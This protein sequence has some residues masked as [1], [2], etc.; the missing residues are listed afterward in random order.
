[1]IKDSLLPDLGGLKPGNYGGYLVVNL[2][3]IMHTV[4]YHSTV[5]SALCKQ[6]TVKADA[7]AVFQLVPRPGSDAVDVKVGYESILA[8]KAGMLLLSSL[9]SNQPFT[10]AADHS[11]GPCTEPFGLWSVHMFIWLPTLIAGPLQ[12]CLDAP[13]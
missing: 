8:C 7:E 5:Y 9:L 10:L 3:N 1:M 4:R 11:I 6:V 13:H 12:Y 2:S